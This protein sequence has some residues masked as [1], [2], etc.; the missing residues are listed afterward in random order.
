L[1]EIIDQSEPQNE[2]DAIFCPYLGLKEDAATS[3]AYP[4][5][6][7]ICHHCKP[8]ESP[9]L[10]HQR[11]VCLSTAHLSCPV[12]TSE[13]PVS[14][15]LS[16]RSHVRK[17]H[18][19]LNKYWLAGVLIV[20]ILAVGGFLA[21]NQLRPQGTPLLDPSDVTSTT[22]E[23]P[24]SGTTVNPTSVE[25][26]SL[27]PVPATTTPLPSSTPSQ[28]TQTSSISIHS[29]DMPIGTTHRFVIH[30]IQQGESMGQLASQ[31]NTTLE[32]IS[33]VNYYMPSPVWI[34]WLVIIPVDATDM[35]GLP[36]FEPYMVVKGGITVENLATDLKLDATSLK[37]YNGLENG[38]VLTG[39]EWLIIPHPGA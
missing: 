29:L 8:G 21:W 23:P 19:R 36:S 5:S 20:V 7:N 22:E 10:E 4:S 34:N 2:T 16:F 17:S 11:T 26:I 13:S 1:K 27:T 12:F 31:Y 32:A 28:D 9:R 39:G 14:L 37:F 15:P 24:A 6:W 30:R 25:N 3:L 38:Y 33:L 35:T 18:R